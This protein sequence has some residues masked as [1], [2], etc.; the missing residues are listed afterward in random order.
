MIGKFRTVVDRCTLAFG[1]VSGLVILVMGF[2]LTY[3]VVCRYFFGSPTIWAQEISIYLYVWTMLAAASYTLKIKKHINVDLV[4][5]HLPT[6]AR[7]LLEIA[8]SAIGAI[9]CA[10][11]T[12]QG[13]EMIAATVQFGKVSATP[14]RVPMWIPQSALLIGFLLLTF[15]FSFII[16]DRAVELG[17]HRE[18]GGEPS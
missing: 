3:E 1:M 9:F 11:I 13:Y 5:S 8:T 12:V 2:I 6:R 17:T 18:K 14:L 16:L 15:Q 7:A 10:I 4:I